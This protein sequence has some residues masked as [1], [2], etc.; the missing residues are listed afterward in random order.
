M[1]FDYAPDWIARAIAATDYA[2]G[3]PLSP[4]LPCAPN[5]PTIPQLAALVA[6]L[7]AEGTLSWEQLCALGT[8]PELTQLLTQAID[9]APATR[10]ASR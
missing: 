3:S 5:H 4:P 10:R 8:Q 2:N 1:T 7:F 6:E 9:E